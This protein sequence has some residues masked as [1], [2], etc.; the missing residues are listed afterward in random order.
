MADVGM[1]AEAFSGDQGARA[2]NRWLGNSVMDETGPGRARE[3][4]PDVRLSV[5]VPAYNEERSITVVVRALLDVPYQ[6]PVEIV[7]VD[8]GS[9]DLTAVK[10]KE[11]DDP[12][13]KIHRH[14]SN[15]GKGAAVVT[16]IR[17]ATGTYAL[18]FDADLEYDP[19]DIPKLVA[20]VQRDKA[21]VVYGSRIHGDH[22]AFQSLKYALGGRLTTV[23]ANILYN[24]YLKDLHTCLKLLP[25]DLARELPLTENGFGLDTEITAL[26][27]ALGVRPLEVPVSYYG[28]TS[29][30]G[31]KLTWRHGVECLWVLTRVRLRQRST[32]DDRWAGYHRTD[33][34]VVDREAA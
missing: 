31:K 24:A 6:C 20:P 26:I 2:A 7:V 29:G 11:F 13:L 16:G 22:T 10:L 25:L 15:K 17:N 27:L 8:D 34:V 23:Y 1:P 12:R 3:I 30:E 19:C 28:R 14:H 9:S 4:R 5:I 33:E 21:R 32:V 18:I